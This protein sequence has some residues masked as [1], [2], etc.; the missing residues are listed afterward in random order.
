MSTLDTLI[1]DWLNLPDAAEALG[2]EVSRVRRLIDDGALVEVRRGTPAVRHVPAE[3][4]ID[5]EVAPHLPGTITVLRDAGFSD[6]ELLVW[7]FTEDETL[8]GRPID[9]LRRG[10]RGEVRRRAQAM[11]F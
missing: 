11:A 1:S 9:H 8:P 10:Q 2:V 4:I 6:E 7:L 5:G 3:M